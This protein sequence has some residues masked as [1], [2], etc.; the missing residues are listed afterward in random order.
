M[1]SKGR[2]EDPAND[3]LTRPRDVYAFQC[4]ARC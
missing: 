2:G 3:P 4:M 1:A